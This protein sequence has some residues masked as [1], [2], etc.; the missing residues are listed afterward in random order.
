MEDA[1]RL[2]CVGI[3]FTIY[4]GS[5]H[6][7]EMYQQIR[8]C[9]EIAKRHGL[10]VMIWSYARGSGLSKVGETAI[11]VIGYAA[12]I[13]AQL[14][15]HIIKV[16]LPNEHVEQDAA[17]KVYEQE[18]IPIATLSQRVHHVVQCAFNG[19]RIVIF[20]GGPID[21]DDAFLNEVRAIHAGHGFGSIIG[22]NSFQRSK[23]DALR[24]LNTIMDI[25]SEQ[26]QTIRTPALT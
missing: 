17:R 21:S 11:D 10:V 12:Q 8:A 4:P 26:S 7:F 16:K 24:L 25:Y 5:A 22:R 3:G 23:P 18:Q 13:A 19:R 15:A 14:G 9:A 2:G 6:R 20:S 1:L